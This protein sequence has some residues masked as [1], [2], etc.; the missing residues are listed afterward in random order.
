MRRIEEVIGD[1]DI[2]EQKGRN[3]VRIIEWFQ[4]HPGKRFDVNEVHDSLGDEL[5]VGEGQVRNYLNELADEGVLQRYGEKRIGY[6]LADDIIVPVRYRVRP[7]VSHLAAIFDIQRWGI[8]SVVVL[9]T[10]LLALLTIP[11]W[12]FWDSLAIQPTDSYGP[13]AQTDFLWMALVTGVWLAIFMSAGIV[14]YR[15]HRGY[16]QWSG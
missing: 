1:Y 10:A 6:Q 7:I 11:F 4:K 8:A 14:L 5:D 12:F 16:Q 9:T 15:V 13:L 3:K 2:T